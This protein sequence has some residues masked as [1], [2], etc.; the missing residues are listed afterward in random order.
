[1]EQRHLA[2]DVS[3]GGHNPLTR[4]R[5]REW[6]EAAAEHLARSKLSVSTPSR[7]MMV[8]FREG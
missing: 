5:D 6:L 4:H 3:K 2:C 1:M 8:P 7:E